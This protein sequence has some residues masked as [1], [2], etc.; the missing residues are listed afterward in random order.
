MAVRKEWKTLLLCVIPLFAVGIAALIIASLIAKD[1]LSYHLTRDFG[2]AL[3]ISGLVTLGYE[4]YARRTFDLA[5]IEKLLDTVY[6]SGVPPDIWDNIKARILNRQV[7][8]RNTILHV[9]VFR[10]PSI[11]SDKVV[12]GIDLAYDLANLL[13][14]ESQYKVIHGLDEHI[15]AAHLPRFTQAS[16]GMHSERINGRDPWN[17]E[18]TDMTVESGRLTLDVNLPAAREDR[19]VSLRIKR[20]EFRWCPGSYYLIMSE[21]TQGIKI[22]LDECA[23]DA[24]V[25]LF[26]YPT[27]QEVNLTKEQIAFIE[28]PLLPG[29]CLEFKL[30]E[31]Y[32]ANGVAIADK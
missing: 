13:N 8:R 16:I 7:V 1:S 9:N 27:S 21:I 26:L 12:L 5:K 10:T 14:K 30:I 18:N 4:A 11:G 28:E 31:K 25:T 24:N 23:E 3:L 15:A 2:I 22:Y 19:P 17:S 20:E 29:H 6:G 32:D